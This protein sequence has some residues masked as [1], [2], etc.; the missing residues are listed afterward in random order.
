MLSIYKRDSMV[1][2]RRSKIR[3]GD[4]V[5]LIKDYEYILTNARGI[6]KTITISPKT[7]ETLYQIRIPNKFW[8][9][10]IDA[11]GFVLTCKADELKGVF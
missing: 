9:R 3:V 2:I 6:V 5:E 4:I 7:K 11:N 10:I 8:L 1:E